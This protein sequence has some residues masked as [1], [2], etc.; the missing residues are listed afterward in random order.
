MSAPAN[1]HDSIPAAH[2]GYGRVVYACSFLSALVVIVGVFLAVAFPDRNALDPRHLFAALW[3][4]W[5]ARQIRAQVGAGWNESGWSPYPGDGLIHV[6]ILLGAIGVGLA[7]FVAA[8][9]YLQ[10]DRREPLWATL[11]LVSALLV[12]AAVAS[13]LRAAA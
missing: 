8:T 10:R 5:D 13:V 6:G 3:K 4:G 2:Y 9:A 11:C 7:L 1:D 12:F